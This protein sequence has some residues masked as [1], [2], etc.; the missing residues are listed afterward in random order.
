VVQLKKIVDDKKLNKKIK[1]LKKGEMCESLLPHLNKPNTPVAV[2]KPNTP[3]AVVNP[4]MTKNECMDKFKVVQLK[5]IVDDKK[6]NKKIKQ[7][8]KGEMCENL[9]EHL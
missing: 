9:L 4:K 6:L 2:V 7:L 8:K 3:V 5:K 1:Q